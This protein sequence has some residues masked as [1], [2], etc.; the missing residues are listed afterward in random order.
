MFF[1][2][3]ILNYSGLLPFSV[4]PRCQCVYSVHSP[5]LQQNW[6]SSEKS[7]NFKEKTLIN[8]HPVGLFVNFKNNSEELLALSELL[9]RTSKCK[10]TRTEI[11]IR[12]GRFVPNNNNNPNKMYTWLFELIIHK[13]NVPAISV[14]P[15]R[16][17]SV[18][19]IKPH[20]QKN[21]YICTIHH[22]YI[23]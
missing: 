4:F 13:R 10:G 9:F 3:K 5:A 22:M 14:C 7:Q 18:S 11:I 20:L 15:K 16:S 6:Q 1:F 19:G 2:S 8:E 23:I 17:A 12:R 21:I